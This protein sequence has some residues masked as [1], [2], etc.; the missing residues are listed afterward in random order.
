MA[1][2]KKPISSRTLG[3]LLRHRQWWVRVFDGMEREIC[4]KAYEELI[5]KMRENSKVA[6]TNF[7][8]KDVITGRTYILDADGQ[9]GYIN[10]KQAANDPEMIRKWR[11]S[12]REYGI[13]DNPPEARR[14]C[15]ESETREV[16]KN[17]FLM[18]RLI[19]TMNS[20]MGIISSTR[21]LLN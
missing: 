16:M 11:S 5:K 1:G 21:S 8:I 20:R 17:P 19:K 14:M 13:V 7:W 2:L 9:L 15:D 12:K 6:R 3:K 10:A 4:G 18:G